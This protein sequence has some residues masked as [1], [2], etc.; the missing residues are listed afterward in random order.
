MG[1]IIRMRS[2]THKLKCRG[3]FFR[4]IE[5]AEVGIK[6]YES[7]EKRQG[8]KGEDQRVHRISMRK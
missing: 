3:S 5:L 8:N 2:Q 6:M 4:G 1:K 7:G